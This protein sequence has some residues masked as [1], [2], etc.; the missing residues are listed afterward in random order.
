M[1]DIF[2]YIKRKVRGELDLKKLQSNGL[3]V[4]KNFSCGNGCFLDPAHCFLIEIGDNVTLASKVHV[5]AHDASTKKHLGY[6]KIGCVSI[7]SNV[8]I[9]ANTTVLP[10]II[11]GRNS[12][13]AAGSV[14]TKSIPPDEVW[15][16][17]PAKKIFDLDEYLDKYRS[18]DGFYFFEEEYTFRGKITKEKQ[19]EM[20]N[21]IKNKVG[22]VR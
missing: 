4:G 9:G 17:V 15:G 11:I 7:E 21:K 20:K 1:K 10:N 13:V 12:I 5:L 18:G 14:V 2:V 3:V 8:F 16:G 6:A 19:L 22:F